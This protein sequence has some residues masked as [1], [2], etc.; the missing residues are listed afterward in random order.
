MKVYAVYE[1]DSCLSYASRDLLGIYS[2]K[3]KAMKRIKSKT[4]L[5]DNDRWNLENINQTQCREN[6]DKN[7]MIECITVNEDL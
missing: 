1:T 3:N 6:D 7:Y 4:E 2:T 5:D